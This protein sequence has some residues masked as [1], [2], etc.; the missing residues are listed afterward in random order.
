MAA[1]SEAKCPGSLT[2][3]YLLVDPLPIY[4][5]MPG[6]YTRAGRAVHVKGGRKRLGGQVRRLAEMVM[7]ITRGWHRHTRPVRSETSSLCLLGLAVQ[8]LTCHGQFLPRHICLPCQLQRYAPLASAEWNTQ[9]QGAAAATKIG[10]RKI[11]EG[12]RERKQNAAPRREAKTAL[13]RVSVCAMNRR[14]ARK[15]G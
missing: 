12:E 10:V 9:N 11:E 3:Q 14:E 15:A 1:R 4:S 5:A 7:R 13:G 6:V 2:E 8:L